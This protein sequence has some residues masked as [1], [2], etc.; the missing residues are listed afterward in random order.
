[1]VVGTVTGATAETATTLD[2]H[3]QRKVT[4]THVL[5]LD[6]ASSERDTKDKR[7]SSMVTHLTK[8]G[9]ANASRR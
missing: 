2:R 7:Q 5:S 6:R 4:E 3:D 8:E 1:M 9:R